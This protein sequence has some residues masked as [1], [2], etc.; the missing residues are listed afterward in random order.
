IADQQAGLFGYDCRRRGQAAAT[1]GT[2]SFVN[3]VVGPTAPAQGICKTYLAWEIA[4]RPCYSLEADMTVTGAAV[5]WLTQ[6]HLLRRAAGLDA[7]AGSVPDSGGLVFVPAFTG[8]GVPSED[9][10]A[11]GSILGMTLGTR[12][13]HLARALLEAIGCQLSAI[14]AT[15]QREADLGIPELRIGGGL[16]ASDLTCQI[17]ADLAGVRLVRARH[18]ET[19]VRAAALLAGLG[20]GSWSGPAQLPPLLDGSERTFEPQLGEAERGEILGRWRRAIEMT[21]T[22][23]APGPIEYR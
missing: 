18:A 1:H 11:R 9:R 6:M 20:A 8:L 22:A 4:A 13:A 3:V 12:P 10:T 5:R 16:A 17:Q 2:A 15:M 23:Q 7:L 19:S 21:S 14:L